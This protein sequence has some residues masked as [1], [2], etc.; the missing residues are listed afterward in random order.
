MRAPVVSRAAVRTVSDVVDPRGFQEIDLHV[1][2]GEGKPFRRELAM[3]DAEEPQIVR[4][5][6]LH[7]MQIARVIDTAGEIRVLEVDALVQLVAVR[8][9][10]AGDVTGHALV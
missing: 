10:A 8:R 4:A 1:A 2:Y 9:Q 7:E 6:A 3:M 5:A